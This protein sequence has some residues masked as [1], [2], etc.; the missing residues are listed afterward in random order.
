MINCI[1]GGFSNEK[2][3]IA[4]DGSAYSEHAARMTGEFLKARPC[5]LITKDYLPN[6][7][8]QSLLLTDKFQAQSFQQETRELHLLLL[9]QSLY[10][11]LLDVGQITVS[12]SNS[13]FLVK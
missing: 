8:L 9:F 5:E 3:I 13:I 6:L 4:T 10:V 1:L 2:N 12:K 11:C 7:H